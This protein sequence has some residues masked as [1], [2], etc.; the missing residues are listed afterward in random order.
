VKTWKEIPLPE[1][2]MSATPSSDAWGPEL[3]LAKSTIQE[4][5]ALVKYYYDIANVG[6]YEKDDRTPLTDADLA[7][8][9]LIRK[10]VAAAFPTDALL[11]EEFADDPSRLRHNRIWIAD[12]ID[13]TKQFVNRTGEFDVFLALAVDGRPVVGVAAHPPS[14]QLM[15]A[16]E[17]GGAWIEQD[18][19]VRPLHFPKVRPGD[20]VRVVT[21]DYHGA[22]ATL[23]L[24][25]RATQ[26]AGFPPP[27]SLPIGFQARAFADP[28]TARPR[29]EIFVGPGRDIDG[30]NYSGAEWDNAATDLIVHEAGGAFT[31]IRGRRFAYNKPDARNFG[32]IFAATDPAVHQRFLKALAAELPPMGDERSVEGGPGDAR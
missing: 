18:G 12:P 22:P 16:T 17:G 11:T 4:A 20:P 1:E 5:S 25:A 28:A 27:T 15:W 30:P 9:R 6:I 10:R 32:G 24:F 23:P 2:P 7:S 31:D 19:E 8:D 3:S 21:S 13:G 29:Y 26:R 14:G